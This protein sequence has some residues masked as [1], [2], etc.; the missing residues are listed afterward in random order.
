MC[1]DVNLHWCKIERV[2]DP[3]YSTNNNWNGNQENN[4][5]SA[6]RKGFECKIYSR[7]IRKMEYW[8]NIT[9]QGTYTSFGWATQA[10]HDWYVNQPEPTKR[11]LCNKSVQSGS[12]YQVGSWWTVVLENGGS[13]MNKWTNPVKKRYNSC[14]YQQWD[15]FCYILLNHCL[16]CMFP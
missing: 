4:M 7:N 6:C 2:W 10:Y 5:Y 13:P 15:W 12:K 1:A 3:R 14:T 9:N 11:V 8:A 16:Q